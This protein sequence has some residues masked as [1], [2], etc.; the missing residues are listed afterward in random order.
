MSD[1]SANTAA[2]TRRSTAIP[3]SL[4]EDLDRVAFFTMEALE[5][6]AVRVRIDHVDGG[7]SVHTA[8]VLPSGSAA[9]L[10]DPS[11][12]PSNEDEA[13]V[14][15][16]DVCDPGG[17]RIG[18]IFVHRFGSSVLERPE[19]RM[20]VGLARHVGERVE[21]A[22]Q[23]DAEA[24]QRFESIATSSPDAIVTA[25]ARNEIVAW[26]AGAER[27]F[28]Y[29]PDDVL[30]QSLSL[31]VPPRMRGQH[32]AGLARLAS[33][34]EARL[35][36]QSVKVMACRKDGSEFPIELSLSRWMERG[37]QRFGAIIRDMS[38][39]VQT[40]AEL[41]EAAATDPLTGLANRGALNKRLADLLAAERRVALLMIDLDGFKE[42]NDTLGHP[43]GDAVLVE[44]ARRIQKGAG[45]FGLCA[46][47]GGD[48]FVILMEDTANPMDAHW[49]GETLI[50][51]IEVAIGASGALV[52]ISASVGV[53]CTG[54]ETT[55][56][57]T[58]VANADLALYRAKAEGRGRTR[59]FTP[60][61]RHKVAE[62]GLARQELGRAWETGAY[63]LY[64]QPQ[65]WLAD[66]SVRGAEA[67]LR[68][69]HP[70]RGLLAPGAFLPLL[71]SDATA[72][73]VGNWILETACRQAAHWRST[74]RSNFRIAV[75]LFP[76]QFKSG[77]LVQNVEHALRA[78]GLA[79][80]GLEIEITETTIL[81]SDER[82][83][84]QLQRL[85]ALG[86]SLAFDDF[87][88]GFASLSMLR[89]FPVTK[90]KIDR[91][92]VS[93]PDV[94]ER[95]VAITQAMIQMADGLGMTT[96]SEGIETSAQHDQMCRQGCDW[97]QGYLYG[98][99]MPSSNFEMLE[100]GANVASS[101]G[102]R[103]TVRFCA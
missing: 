75:N 89:K 38:E 7:T 34:G 72:V 17:A 50:D 20:L 1:A 57:G 58:L 39:R 74:I 18:S 91:S 43:V 12:D 3:R 46:R 40:E 21:A 54:E 10:V 78:T 81:K 59:L 77:D 33:G 56:A 90:I 25:N 35:L 2:P 9:N 70:E 55:D 45:Q 6:K 65:V 88:T 41:R 24:S 96:V 102:G 27:L 93:G 61:L 53:A 26:N 44:V 14:V 64:Y 32:E 22:R 29:V 23:V 73:A 84:S 86:V 48:E 4:A 71:E 87:G 66:G 94:D 92:F 37:E 60:E 63:E 79:P 82:I 28:G 99:P 69:N 101:A 100:W 103:A 36:G 68:W 47:M 30:G 13:G 52:T 31:I 62:R 11:K 67:L 42:V 19:H 15:R 97:G 5:A 98:R 83:L 76:I 95:D 85:R 49:L 8:G 16:T 51:A 80:D